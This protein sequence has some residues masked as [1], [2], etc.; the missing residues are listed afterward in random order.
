VNRRAERSGSAL[1]VA[2]WTLLLL[3][4]LLGSLA[5]DMHVEAAVTSFRRRRVRAELLAR[6]GIA[7]A[8]WMLARR[9]RVPQEW[10]PEEMPEDVYLQ[11]RR[12][13][14]HL[15]VRELRVP[16]NGGDAIRLTIEPENARRNVNALDADDWYELLYRAGVP[17]EQ[18]DALLACFQDWTDPDD[19]HR[20]LGAESDDAF[21]TERGYRVRNGPVET[22]AEL[23][24]IKGFSR[25]LLYGGPSPYAEGETLRG[26]AAWLTTRGDGRVHANA[27][28]RDVLLTIPG[29]AEADADGIIE[30]AKGPDGEPGTEDDGFTDATAFA[31]A[32]GIAD[33]VVWERLTFEN[34]RFFRV[35]SVGVADGVEHTVRSVWRAE[36]VRV[37]AI[38]W[39]EGVW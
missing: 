21:Y 4:L 12:L 11:L 6:S 3:T 37:V 29:L 17:E 20:L 24:M 16:M 23:A 33:P 34:E 28:D 31:A 5:F 32:T 38:E 7:Y 35:T 19:D 25:E 39:M 27:A 2:L 15:P 14:R 22:V 26:I 30:A 9:E 36:A 13:Q 8:Q 10:V 1:I 18:W